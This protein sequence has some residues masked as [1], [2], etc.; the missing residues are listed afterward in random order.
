[1]EMKVVMINDCASVGQTL[2]KYMPPEIEK[3]QL[4]R[5]RGPWSKTFGIAYDILRTK[6]DIYQA[7]Y[8]FQDCYLASRFG[9]HPLIGYSVGSDLRVLLN[10]W[11][12]G[13]L[14]RHNL[15]RCDGI[16]VS[17]PDLVTIATEFRRD[18]EYLPP[19]VDPEFFYEKPLEPH[20]GKKR[21]LIAS[22]V[23]LA[24]GTDVAIRALSRLKEE[25]DVS[26]IAFGSAV[27]TML[28]LGSSLGM[29]INVLPEVP[30]SK[31]NQYFWDADLVMDQFRC[32]VPG[33]TSLEA[34]SCGRPSVTNVSSSI[35]ELADFPLKDVN[36]EDRIIETI[37][38][39]LEDK[40]ILKKEME[41]VAATHDAYAVVDKLLRIYDR[42]QG[43]R[44]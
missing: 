41:Y 18:V 25:V 16:M 9:K 7:N 4:V 40:T 27:N 44:S 37:Y 10:H 33:M 32:G 17:T 15:K 11:I 8:L 26:L 43:R 13:R 19:P 3:Q 39:T 29:K 31:V 28:R 30:H 21:I 22:N 2:L 24:K 34:I 14:V 12:W 5:T 1:M 38:R 42:V 35:P 36:D 20:E 6:S 23:S